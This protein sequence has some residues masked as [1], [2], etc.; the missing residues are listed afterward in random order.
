MSR[1]YVCP[2]WM[3][4][5]FDNPA[6]RLFH[7]P[8][9]ML[10]PWVG[11]GDR[12]ADIGCGIGFFS[13]GLARLVGESGRVYAM[14]LQ[15]KMLA[16]VERRAQKAGLAG[17]IE[18]RKVEAGD[19]VASDLKGNL[20]MVLAFWMLHEVPDQAAFLGQVRAL[21]KPGGLFL[22]AEPRFHVRAKAFE[23]SLAL[24]GEIGMQLKER[25]E[26]RLSRAALFAAA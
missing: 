20:D 7:K 6:R 4:H 3:I 24:A 19:L 21:L 12:V 16:G 18:T 26:V 1:E 2:W 15:E 5:T 23:K 14:D 9:K 13:L 17:R 11:A 25:P 8:E 10:S 22:L